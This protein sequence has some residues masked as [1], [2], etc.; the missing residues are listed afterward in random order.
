MLKTLLIILRF[1]LV[2]LM[3]C[4][5]EL[6]HNTLF[7]WLLFAGM[8]GLYLYLRMAGNTGHAFLLLMA[9]LIG[10]A[11]IVFISW[12][13]V[14]SVPAVDHRNPEYTEIISLL[15]GE[16]RGVFNKDKSVE[17]Y[18]GIPYAKAPVGELRWKEPQDPKPW[19][20][21]LDADHFKPMS[22]QTVSMPLIDSLTRIIGYHDY[23]ISVHDNYRPPVSEDSLYLNVWKPAGKQ[24]D[25]PVLV[26]I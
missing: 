23:R 13:P 18:A 2:L 6:N 1:L 15:D 5:L 17:V 11:V 9:Y 19:D 4:F 20:G 22:M 16:I 12:P 26:Y 7:G 21:I 8:T 14:R 25:L 24:Q 3:S 10:F